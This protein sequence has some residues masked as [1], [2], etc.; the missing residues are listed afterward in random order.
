M[1][2]GAFEIRLLQSARFPGRQ[3]CRMQPSGRLTRTEPRTTAQKVSQPGGVVDG[4]FHAELERMKS[5]HHIKAILVIVGGCL[6]VAGCVVHDQPFY[7][8]APAAGVVVGGEVVVTEPP[9]APV[10]ETITVSPGPGFV[11]I[12]GYWG[13][14]GGRWH[15]QTGHWAAPPHRGAAW[16][17]PRYY[18]HG[19]RHVWVHG[20]WR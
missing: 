4:I 11:W 14:G 19:G 18:H 2:C 13:W 6:G 16:V 15:W 17:S 10:V 3:V 8:S 1:T 5:L 20:G 7:T 9:P 12:G